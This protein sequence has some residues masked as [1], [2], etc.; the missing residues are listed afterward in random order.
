MKRG[1]YCHVVDRNGARKVVPFRVEDVNLAS[2]VANR[3]GHKLCSTHHY[4]VRRVFANRV[5]SSL[6]AEV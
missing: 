6:R 4:A 1:F 3:A 5:C 2:S